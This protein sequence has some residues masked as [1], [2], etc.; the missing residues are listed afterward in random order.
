MFDG[1][2][3][4]KL[5]A[6]KNMKKEIEDNFKELLKEMKDFYGISAKVSDYYNNKEYKNDISKAVEYD[7]EFKTAYEKFNSVFNK[8]NQ[9]IKKY[10]PK[11]KIRDLQSIKDPIQKSM[12][13]LLNSYEGTI[14]LAEEFYDEF[15]TLKYKDDHS[16]AKEKINK[17]AENLNKEKNVVQ[18]I[19]FTDATKHMKYNYED[20]FVK[21][22]EEFI[23]SAN[24]LFEKEP[25]IKSEAEYNQLYNDVVNSYN[26]MIYIYNA[27]TQAINTFTTY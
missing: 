14:E 16:K 19:E 7:E 12:A 26:S 13:A 11:R 25:S 5:T 6:S 9:S 21:T 10:K 18:S 17:Y 4:S 24:T 27:N 15:S 23:K 22:S 1:G 3:L 8:F 20:H 2:E